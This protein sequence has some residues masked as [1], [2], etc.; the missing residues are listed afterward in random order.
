MEIDL[1][2]KMMTYLIGFDIGTQ[3]SKAILTDIDGNVYAKKQMNH[4]IQMLKPGYQEEDMNLWWYE[5]KDAIREFLSSTEVKAEEIKAIGI[6]GLVPGLC[7]IDNNGNSIRNAILHTDVRAVKELEYINNT[8]NIS[9]SH[10]CLLPKLIWI[11]NNEP[12]NYNKIYKV[13]VPHGYIAYKLTGTSTMDYDTATV[14]GGIFD[15]KK[16]KWKDERIELFEMGKDIFPE[17]CPSN[18]VIGKVSDEVAKETGLSVNTKVIAGTGDTFASMLGGGAYEKKHLMIYL[19]TSTTIIYADGSPEN[20]ID[21]PH[22]SDGRGNFVGRILSFGESV[23]HLKNILRYDGWD[24]LDKSLGEEIPAGAEGLYY[25]P[26][27]KQQIQKSFFGLDAEYILGLRGNHNQFHLYKALIEGIAYN[28]KSNISGFHKEINQINIFGGGADSMEI[29]K[30][31]ADI[32]GRA[33]RFSEK[34][35][36]VLGIAFLAGYGSGEIKDFSCLRNKWYNDD[37]TI[38]PNEG[39]V[40]LYNSLYLK[41]EKIKANLYALDAQL[42]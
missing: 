33:V 39:N 41:Y 4:E 6:T 26:H 32:L 24:E 40:V 12:E 3:G 35:S 21:L 31:I 14:V 18:R 27:Y 20:Y 25:I 17:L 30:I 37:I 36:T 19:G 16:L 29:C 15:E 11:K 9:I 10:G 28:I 38:L 7:L 1:R 5:F 13:M 8:Q 22:F 42:N 2:G 23:S 34:K